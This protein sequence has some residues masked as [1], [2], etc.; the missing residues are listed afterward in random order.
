[1][2]D[3]LQ[4][5]WG[6]AWALGLKRFSSNPQISFLPHLL[7]SRTSRFVVYKLPAHSGS[8][9]TPW[10]GLMYKYMDQNSDGWQDG[11]GYI[12]SSKGAVGL[13][14]QP[15]YRKNSSQVTKC[16][17]TRAGTLWWVPRGREGSYVAS[18]HSPSWPFYSTTTN[19]LN[20]AQLGTL[21]A[22]GIRRVRGLDWWSWSLPE[23]LVNST[24][25][26]LWPA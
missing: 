10:K 22:M 2:R 1:M 13:S 12:N 21:P 23:F 15:L 25:T 3:C 24:L 6:L 16:R 8:G 18:V 26:N 11:V 17:G 19:L 4:T 5:E 14:L 7:S 9:D 20:P